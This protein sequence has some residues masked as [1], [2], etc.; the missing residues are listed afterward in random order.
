MGEVR[1]VVAEDAWS[2]RRRRSRGKP[3][4]GSSTAGA[5]DFRGRALRHPVHLPAARLDAS[6]HRP[7]AARNSLCF[8]NFSRSASLSFLHWIPGAMPT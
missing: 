4:A 6:V 8:V 5:S 2:S 1:A 7:T 3:I